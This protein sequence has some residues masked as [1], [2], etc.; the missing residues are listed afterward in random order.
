MT[1]DDSSTTP[2][3]AYLC[4]LTLEV[5]SDP[6]ISKYGHSYERDAIMEWLA[7]GNAACPLTRNPLSP[8]MLIP[9]ISLRLYIRSWQRKHGMTITAYEKNGE[10]KRSKFGIVDADFAPIS[11]ERRRTLLDDDK[12]SNAVNRITVEQGAAAGSASTR[13]SRPRRRLLNFMGRR[14]AGQQSRNASG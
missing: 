1:A 2:P 8:S 9:N 6:L 3:P 14:S 13:A 12:V 10:E 11:K 7:Q 4:P 5:M